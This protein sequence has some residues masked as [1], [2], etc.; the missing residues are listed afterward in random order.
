[1]TIDT[2]YTQIHHHR[3]NLHTNT[4]PSIQLTH[5]YITIDTTYTQIHHHRYN[6][7]T[8]TSPSIQLTHKY[9]TIDTTYTQIHGRS[10]HGLTYIGTSKNSS[11]V[12]FLRLV[13]PMLPV[14]LDCSY[15]ITPSV[16]SNVYLLN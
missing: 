3:Y 4:S 10:I 16:F 15:L 2:T 6:L 7:H 11:R 1:M 5:K 9:I 13:H 14:S 12:V 8:N